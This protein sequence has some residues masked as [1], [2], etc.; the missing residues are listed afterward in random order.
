MTEWKSTMPTS[1]FSQNRIATM[2]Q[3]GVKGEGYRAS[4]DLANPPTNPIPQARPDV[5][6]IC[7]LWMLPGRYNSQSKST[8]ADC[9]QFVFPL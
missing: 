9:A 8:N 2:K 1:S 3:S 5:G 6:Y 4:T 7:D